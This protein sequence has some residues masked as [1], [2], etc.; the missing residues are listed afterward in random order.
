LFTI[1]DLFTDPI[2]FKSY[3]PTPSGV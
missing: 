3:S 1:K 2:Q